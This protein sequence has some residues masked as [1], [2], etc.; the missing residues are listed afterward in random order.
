MASSLYINKYV[1]CQ[2]TSSLNIIKYVVAPSNVAITL[3][4][5]IE[6]VLEQFT[7]RIDISKNY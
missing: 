1:A 3:N 5:R 6:F 2:L 4:S 7:L